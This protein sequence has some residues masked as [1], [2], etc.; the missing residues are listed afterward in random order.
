MIVTSQNM[1]ILARLALQN[2]DLLLHYLRTVD[3]SPDIVS[4]FVDKWAG[5]KVDLP[6][7]DT[8]NSLTVSACPRVEN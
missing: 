7:V 8:D 3:P 1:N 6:R 2:P 4:R 5:P